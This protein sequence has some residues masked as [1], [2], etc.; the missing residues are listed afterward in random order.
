MKRAGQTQIPFEQIGDA[1]GVT[2]VWQEPT[3]L[4]PA[5]PVQG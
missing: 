2:S 1:N 4:K 3:Q 5:L